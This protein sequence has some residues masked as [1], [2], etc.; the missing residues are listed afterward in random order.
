MEI[1]FE[2]NGLIA[3]QGNDFV[4]QITLTH[5]HDNVYQV[6]RVYVEPNFRGQGIAEK[7]VNALV[8]HARISNLKLVPV[9]SYAVAYFAKN[10]KQKDV[11]FV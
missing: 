11:L 5:Q 6:V 9:C 10:K 2:P 3:K 8:E 4:G 1:K 7:L